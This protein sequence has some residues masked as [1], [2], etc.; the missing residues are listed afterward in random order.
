MTPNFSQII[1]IAK[2]HEGNLKGAPKPFK[3]MQM[4]IRKNQK[5]RKSKKIPKKH[6]LLN[7]NPKQMDLILDASVAGL[8]AIFQEIVNSFRTNAQN[9]ISPAIQKINV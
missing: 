1:A 2:G 6:L 9:V 4:Q 5:V 8:L 7:K 3:I